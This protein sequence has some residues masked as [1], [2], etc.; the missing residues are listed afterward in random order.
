MVLLVDIH[1]EYFTRYLIMNIFSPLIIVLLLTTHRNRYDVLS[2]V[3][4]FSLSESLSGKLT[5]RLI[6]GLTQLNS[7][8]TP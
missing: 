7:N 5:I 6:F 1:T 8:S 4:K 2:F 3:E